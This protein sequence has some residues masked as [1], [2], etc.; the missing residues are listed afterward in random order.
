MT[1]RETI[2][3]TDT[4]LAALWASANAKRRAGATTAKAD[5]EALTAL[6]KDHHTLVT[7]LQSRKLLTILPH[8]DLESLK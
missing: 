2:L 6:L 7:A 4:A 5:A 8:A 3:T 1:S